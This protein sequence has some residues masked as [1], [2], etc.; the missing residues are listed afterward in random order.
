MADAGAKGSVPKFTYWRGT[1]STSPVLFSTSA[2]TGGIVLGAKHL[3]NLF[4]IESVS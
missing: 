2:G 1:H 3:A 4:I